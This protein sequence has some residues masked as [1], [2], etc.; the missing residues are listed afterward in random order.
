MSQST[1]SNHPA[2]S[3]IRNEKQGKNTYDQIQIYF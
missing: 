3:E 2:Q 1:T